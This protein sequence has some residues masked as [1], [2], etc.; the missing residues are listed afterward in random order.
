MCIFTAKAFDSNDYHD[1]NVMYACQY[2]CM[3]SNLVTKF[4]ESGDVV[5]SKITDLPKRGISESL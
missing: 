1:N 4:C 2:S 5:A 3:P